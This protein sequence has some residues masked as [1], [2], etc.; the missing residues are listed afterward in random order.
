[1]LMFILAIS[2]LTTSNFPWFMELTFQ[3][4]M[5]YCSLQH[6]TLLPSPVTSTTDCCFLLWLHLFIL[7]GVI[8]PLFSSSILGTYWPGEIIF[9]CCVFLP[10]HTVHGVLKARIVKLFA[11]AFSSGPHFIRTLHHDPYILVWPTWHGSCVHWIRQGCGP[12][13][14]FDWFS[15]IVVFNLSVLWWIRIKSFLMGETERETGSCSDELGAMLSKSLI[16]FSVDGWGCVPSLLFDLRLNYGGGNEN[17][18]DLLQKIPCPYCQCHWPCTRPLPTHASARDSWTLMDKSGSVCC[19][20]TTPFSWVLV[21]TRFCLCPLRICFP[22]PVC[23]GGSKVGLMVTSSKSAYPIPRSAAPRDPAPAAGH[24]WPVPPQETLRHSKAGLV[25][26]LWSLLMCTTFC[27]SPP[28]VSCWYEVWFQKR[29]CPSYW[30]A[31]ASLLPLDMTCVFLVGSN[32]LQSTVVQ[33]QVV[34]LEFSQEKMNSLMS[35]W[36]K[37]AQS[38]L[39]LSMELSRPEYWSG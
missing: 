1:M 31:G 26:S 38:C 10:F 4:S 29:F 5:Q 39:T 36:V 28:R 21:H 14:Q 32:I 20:V 27:L 33:Q 16:Q 7:S 24:F 30:L 12:C 6:R 8:S 34:I 13:D 37:V 17:N 19:G 3:V 23:S 18:G 22:S 15:L 11:I 25:Q 9:Q 2:Y 35:G